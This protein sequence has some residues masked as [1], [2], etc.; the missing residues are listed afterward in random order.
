MTRGRLTE[1]RSPMRQFS[2]TIRIQIKNLLAYYFQSSNVNFDRV[3]S[4]SFTMAPMIIIANASARTRYGWY[5]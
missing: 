5:R 4:R 2:V 1:Q 3:Y